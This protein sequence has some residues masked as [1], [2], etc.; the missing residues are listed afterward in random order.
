M[1]MSELAYF[2]SRSRRH[3]ATYRETGSQKKR[4]IS[5]R[6]FDFRGKAQTISNGMGFFM[7]A[8]DLSITYIKENPVNFSWNIFIDMS[9]SHIFSDT[10]DR[11][12]R[13]GCHNL[14]EPEFPA[15]F[16]LEL[17]VKYVRAMGLLIFV[18]KNGKA[19]K[20]AEILGHKS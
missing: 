16:F 18:W 12:R 20:I 1:I 6:I 4:Q 15:S 9:T 5:W 8:H 2:R 14:G 10:V 7:Y 13:P 3:E 19:P 11:D 17:L